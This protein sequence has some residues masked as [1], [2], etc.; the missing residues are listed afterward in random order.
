MTKL[1]YLED[2]FLFAGQATVVRVQ[3]LENP[4]PGRSWSV[5]L[6]QTL[7][8]PQG[9]GQ[10]ADQGT[11]STQSTT[12]QVQHTIFNVSEGLVQHLGEFSRGTEFQVGELVNLEVDKD[13]RL[14]NA[15]LHTAGHLLASVLESKTPLKGKK[16]Y[17]FVEGPYVEFEGVL[18]SD[19]TKEMIE[20]WIQEAMSQDLDLHVSLQGEMRYVAIGGYDGVGCGGTHLN[21]AKGL[22]L[23]IRKIASKKGMTTIRYKV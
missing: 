8:Y 15:S 7:F 5:Q 10:P 17:H 18:S 20:Q 11:I 23:E 13:R 19:I 14:L 1:Q 22:K 9:G 16:G 2:T 6:D 3:N 4:Q 21:S 12:F